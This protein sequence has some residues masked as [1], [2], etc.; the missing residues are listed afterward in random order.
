MRKTKIVCTLGPAI[1]DPAVLKRIF[2]SGLDVAR[3]NFSH[4]TYDEH[5]TRIDRFKKIREEVGKP[6]ALL[7]DTKGPEIRLKKFKQGRITLNQGQ[8]FTL[9]TEDIEGDENIVSVTY[10]GLPSDVSRGDRIL[11]DD[12]LIEL[13]VTGTSITEVFCD[14]I[15]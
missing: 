15:D 5:Q 6:A 10:P 2:K 12:G 13:K 1:D 7:L 8:K 14:V 4:G 11:I 9:T 3:F